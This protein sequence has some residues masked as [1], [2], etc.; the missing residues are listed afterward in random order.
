MKN[1]GFSLLEIMIYLALFGMLMTGVIA[2]VYS[3]FKTNDANVASV[4]IQEE[5][6]FV[7]RKISWAL[8]GATAVNQVSPTSISIVRPDLGAQSPLLLSESG[9]EMVISRGGASPVPLTASRY[10][11][12]NT[13]FTVTPASGGVPA[14]VKVT[15]NVE[16]SPFI[17]KT[18]LRI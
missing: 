18:Y 4:E 8:S 3:I 15:Y 6:T 14:S 5:G 1:R 11:L 12:T 9:T 16:D 2:T 13:N 17:Y 7:N 10:K